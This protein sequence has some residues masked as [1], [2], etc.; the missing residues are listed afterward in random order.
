MQEEEYG[1]VCV[2]FVWV[3]NVSMCVYVLCV[4]CEGQSA[5]CEGVRECIVW[6]YVRRVQSGMVGKWE[7]EGGKV[8]GWEG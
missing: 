1:R 3:W 7:G 4:S 5:L 6:G 2:R 8:G